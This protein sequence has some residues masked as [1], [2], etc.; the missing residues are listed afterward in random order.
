MNAKLVNS[1]VQ[2]IESLTPEEQ[3]LLFE[4]L[5][6]NTIQVTP[7][8]CGGQPRIRNTRIPVWTLVAFRQQGADDEEL[9]R[10]YP[11]LNPADLSATWLYYEQHREECDRVI[12]SLNEDRDD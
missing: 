5:H 1:L 4:R 12:A 11:T 6:N 3:S 7:G 9:L 10:N 8:V 2:I